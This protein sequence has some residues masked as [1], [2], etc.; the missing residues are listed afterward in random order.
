M[1]SNI[2]LPEALRENY[3]DPRMVD[4]VE[5]IMLDMLAMQH[6]VLPDYID[7]DLAVLE[8]PLYWEPA[9]NKI[10]TINFAH[11]QAGRVYDIKCPSDLKEVAK[12]NVPAGTVLNQVVII[13]EC[14]FQFGAN[15]SL[16]D[17]VVVAID[18][19]SRVGSN[20]INF[21]SGARLGAADNCA[22]GGG[23]Q[24]FTN[25]SAKFASTTT[26]DG[27][28]IVAAGDV[29]LGAR[30]M[31]I[32]GISVQAGGNIFMTSNNMF[33]LCSGGAPDLFTVD[34]YRLVL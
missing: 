25:A 4:H 3:L 7:T 31:G 14:G 1:D 33:G 13:S 5:E 23:V 12:A 2:G 11:L 8:A 26:Y 19:G 22:P 29:E 18:G 21:A 10:W 32:N 16:S 27:V 15:V 17:V 9:P 24:I 30:D 28:Q 6:D 20:N 34:Y